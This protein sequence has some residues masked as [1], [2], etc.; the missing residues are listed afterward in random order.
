MR[1]KK[2]KKE[3]K[4]KK[5]DRELRISEDEKSLPNEGAF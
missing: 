2:S 4:D 3:K 5:N 1:F